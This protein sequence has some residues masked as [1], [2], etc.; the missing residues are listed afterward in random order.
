[1]NDQKI[2][3]NCHNVTY[4]KIR[5]A[6]KNGAKTAEEV[7]KVTGAGTACGKCKEFLEYLVR[8]FAEE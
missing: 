8:D 2:A 5:E 1:M 6:V 3:C 4:G 7:A